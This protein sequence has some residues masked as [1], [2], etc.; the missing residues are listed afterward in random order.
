MQILIKAL[1]L[2]HHVVLVFVLFGWAVP[3][4]MVR[5]VHI[6][7]LPLMVLQWQLNKGACLLTNLENYLLGKK[8]ERSEQDSQFIRSAISKLSDW[9]PTKKQMGLIIY[10]AVSISWLISIALQVNYE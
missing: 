5:L 6:I 10:S 2:I 7:F 9:Q 3:S 8:I 4:P 1:R